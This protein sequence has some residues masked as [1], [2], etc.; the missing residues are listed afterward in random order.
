MKRSALAIAILALAGCGGGGSSPGT[1]S[2]GTPVSVPTPSP[3]PTAPLSSKAALRGLVAMGRAP[4]PSGT[5]TNDFEEINAHPA[6]YVATVI[7]LYWSQ[8]EPEQGVFDDTQLQAAL[9]NITA[10]NAKYPA[11][12]VVGKL[13]IRMGAGTPAWVIATTGGVTFTDANGD[14]G[15]IGQYWTPTYASEW[16]ALQAHLA[17]EFDGSSQIAEVAISSCSSLTAEPFIAPQSPSAISALHAAGY[18]DAEG[19]SCLSNAPNDYA[20]WKKTP[21]DFTFNAFAQTDTGRPVANDTFP[22]QVMDAFRAKFGTRGVVANHGLQSPLAPGAVPIYTEF[23][24]LYNEALAA[25]PPSMS[26]LEFQTYSPTVD[27]PTTIA[28]GLTYHPSEI[29]IWDTTA[30]GGA[31]PLTQAQLQSWATSLQ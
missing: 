25:H 2:T 18:T 29:E 26:P 24:N 11:T 7:N 22:I 20:A 13:R 17:S 23:T 9:A 14:T 21:L 19:M 6:V 15:T 12:P 4:S 1:R 28:L 31:A 3:T 5:P 27:W 30:A 8:L 16:Q 10:Y